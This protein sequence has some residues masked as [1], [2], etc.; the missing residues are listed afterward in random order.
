MGDPGL[1]PTLDDAFGGI[2]LNK[3]LPGL[4][5]VASR[6]VSEPP[7]QAP[8]HRRGELPGSEEGWRQLLRLLRST[9]RTLA[10]RASARSHS[11][12]IKSAIASGLL[13]ARA[14][15]AS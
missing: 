3:G 9:L 11:I 1:E 14:M 13:L 10:S 7:A 8:W 4:P 12:G 5:F 6:L 15:D 2:G